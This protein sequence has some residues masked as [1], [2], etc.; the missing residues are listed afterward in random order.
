MNDYFTSQIRTWTPILVGS[1]LSWLAT[2]GLD[3][4]ASSPHILA[5]VT[6]LTG[7]ITA[8]Y[9]SCVRLL[10]RKFP[11]VG[12]LLGSPTPPKYDTPK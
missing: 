8:L 2:Q 9:Y 1:V 12:W 4:D 5:I 10:E 11:Q 6:A 3:I 7:F